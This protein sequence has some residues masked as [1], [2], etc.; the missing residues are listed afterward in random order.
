MD[1]E[2]IVLMLAIAVPSLI[3]GVAWGISRSRRSRRGSSVSSGF[4]DGFD[5]GFLDVF[6]GGGDSGGGD[7]GGGDGGGGGGGGGD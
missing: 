6:D 5:S 4:G 3:V 1:N 2:L 7:G